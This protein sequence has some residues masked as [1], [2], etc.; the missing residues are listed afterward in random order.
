MNGMLKAGRYLVLDLGNYAVK[1]GIAIQGRLIRQ[2]TFLQEIPRWIQ[3]WEGGGW[4]ISVRAP[5]DRLHRWVAERFARFPEERIPHAVGGRPRGMGSDRWVASTWAWHQWR[6]PVLIFLMGSALT[7]VWVD[8]KGKVQGG[9]I[10]PGIRLRI[11]ALAEQAGKLP[12]IALPTLL[13]TYT[14]LDSPWYGN[15]TQ[16]AISAGIL[17]GYI[18]EVQMLIEQFLN[19]VQGANRCMIVFA[20]GDALFLRRWIEPHLQTFNARFPVQWLWRPY[21]VLEALAGWLAT[22]ELSTGYSTD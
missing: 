7:T 2:T 16:A 13:E 20:G 19:A 1:A 15:H 11:A 14:Q 4:W 3:N 18:A 6:V 22:L 21:F 8:Q 10:S 5:S 17:T 12:T 9:T